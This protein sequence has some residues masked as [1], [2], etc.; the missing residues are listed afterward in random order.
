MSG[1]SNSNEKFVLREEKL[2]ISKKRVELAE[3]IMH[4]EV[5]TEDKTITVPV[6]H[7]HLIIEKKKPNGDFETIRIPVKKESIQIIKHPVILEEVS[8][9]IDQI[10]ENKCI[11][12]T[13]KKEVLDVQ[14]K[15]CE[16]V[17]DKLATD[18][19]DT[20]ML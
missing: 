9:H 19:P 3:V 16:V 18:P 17:V 11:T 4:K 7:E 14:T 10:T 12:E 6:V 20:S 15:G 5:F 2:D 8:Y 1:E 13:L